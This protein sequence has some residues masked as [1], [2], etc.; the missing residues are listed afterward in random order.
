MT[1]KQIAI[2]GATLEECA[3]VAPHAATFRH[4]EACP[5]L[6]YSKQCV[7]V[8]GGDVNKSFATATEEARSNDAAEHRLIRCGLFRVDRLGLPDHHD[9]R[10]TRL[11][12]HRVLATLDYGQEI[13]CHGCH[14]ALRG[15]RRRR[16]CPDS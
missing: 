6:L 4:W 10:E 1:S 2:T 14:P 11:V 12:T 7:A 15:H 3:N 16:R 8:L 5:H 9:R 13:L